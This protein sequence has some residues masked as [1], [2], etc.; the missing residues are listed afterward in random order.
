M[1]GQ[2]PWLSTRLER[3]TASRLPFHLGCSL[4]LRLLPWSGAGPSCN[5]SRQHPRP[6]FEDVDVDVWEAVEHHPNGPLAEVRRLL[7]PAATD[8]TRPAYLIEAKELERTETKI[9]LQ[10]SNSCRLG[11]FECMV[12]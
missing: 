10:I 5:F 8:G 4:Y 3:S 7:V 6:S 12:E 2:I 11:T 9:H 1:P